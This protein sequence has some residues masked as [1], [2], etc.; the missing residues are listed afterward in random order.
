[1]AGKVPLYVNMKRTRLV[2]RGVTLVGL[3][4]AGWLPSVMPGFAQSNDGGP[5]ALEIVTTGLW[6]PL[7]LVDPDDGSGRLFVLEKRGVVRVVVDGEVMPEPLL[8]ISDQVNT[9]DWE[10]GALGLALHPRFHENGYLYVTYT[11]DVREWALERYQISAADPNRADPASVTPIIRFFEER[12]YGGHYGGNVTFG[13]DGYLYVSIGDGG[14]AF[15]PYDHAQDL[16]TLMGSILRIDVDGGEPYAIPPDNPFV[17]MPNAR[18]EVW[19]YGLRNP[20]RF[21]IDPETHNLYVGDVGHVE[22]EEINIQP[23]NGSAGQNFGWPIVE[24]FTCTADY[25][26]C[27]PSR[28]TLPAVA[29]SHQVGCSVIGG[30][31]YRGNPASAL[32]GTYLFSDYCSGDVWALREDAYGGQHYELLLDTD[33]NVGALAIDADG[34]LYVLDVSAGGLYKLHATA[35]GPDAPVVTS[36]APAT[37]VAGSVACYLDVYGANFPPDAAITIDGTPRAATFHSSTHLAVA[38]TTADLALPGTLELSVRNPRAAQLPPAISSVSVSAGLTDGQALARTWARTDHPVATGDVERVWLWG[39]QGLT[40]AFEEPYADAAGGSRAVQY[41]DKARMEVTDPDGSGDSEW[42]VTA[43]LLVVEMVRGELQLGDNTFESRAP[44]EIAIAGD[45]DAPGAAT[46]ATF[47]GLLDAVPLE[48]GDTVLQRVDRTGDVT[49]DETLAGYDVTI[50]RHVAETGHAIAA[51]FWELMT[52]EASVW[53][54]VEL[55]TAPL[56]PNPFFATGLP[57]T[58]PYW[59]TITVGATERDVLIQ[60]FERRVLTYTP[61][62][63]P[64]WQVEAGNVGQ[65]YFQW[66]Y[67]HVE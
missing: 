11:P 41:F 20:W 29:Y 47:A 53:D 27:D 50:A 16:R 12:H 24:G 23:A 66:R 61:D 59:A 63:L 25:P 28:Y 45:P 33:L 7:D 32:Y 9:S 65:H 22:W 30:Y 52:A 55:I 39:P 54:G 31:V 57:I 56:V 3:L 36:V 1:M 38:L 2:A 67:L 46:Y 64:G 37:L 8:D 60:V 40:C 58:E 19:A 48:V 18:G 6:E 34:E 10:R 49:V 42:Y 35:A 13:P 17:N 44:A 43:G 51:P 21:S 26:N 5:L 14:G 4:V 15:D 62:N